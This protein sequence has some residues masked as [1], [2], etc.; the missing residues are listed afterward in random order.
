MVKYVVRLT[1]AVQKIQHANVLL[2]LDAGGSNWSEAQAAEAFGCSA[3]TRR[4]NEFWM[5]T[6][7]HRWCGSPTPRRLQDRHAGLSRSWPQA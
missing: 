6:A 7:R 4:V 5:A 2:K 1:A 3:R